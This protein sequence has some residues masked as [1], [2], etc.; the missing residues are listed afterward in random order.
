MKNIEFVAFEDSRGDFWF[1]K[2]GGLLQLQPDGL[3]TDFS[4]A[5]HSSLDFAEISVIYEDHSNTLWIGT[6]GG[7][8]KM[9]VR[10]QLFKNSFAK[11]G[12]GWGNAMRGICEDEKGD[13]FFFCEK[14]NQG[15]HRMNRTNEE[16][17]KLNIKIAGVNDFDPLRHQ[18]CLLHCCWTTH[19]FD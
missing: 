18:G 4:N 2:G 17:N 16:V 8:L 7:L 5:L 6:D 9:P 13:L 3:L 15:L 19:L 10:K 1:R 12:R 11:K 14:G